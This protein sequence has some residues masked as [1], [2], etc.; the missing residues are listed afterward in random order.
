MADIECSICLQPLEACMASICPAGAS[1]RVMQRQHTERQTLL[2]RIAKLED[3]LRKIR[4]LAMGLEDL[5]DEP[6]SKDMLDALMGISD[7]TEVLFED[8]TQGGK[9]S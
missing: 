9:P 6:E 2:A 8:A 1:A 4:D 3:A 7:L 5:E